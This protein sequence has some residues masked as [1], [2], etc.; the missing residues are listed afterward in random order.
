MRRTIL[1]AGV[2]PFVSAFLGGVLAFGLVA[3][4]MATAQSTAQQEVRANSFVLVND[5][6]AVVARLGINP[7]GTGTLWFLR[8]NGTVSSTFGQLGL[9][10]WDAGGETVVMRAGRCLGAGGA[11]CPGGLPPFEGLEL[12]PG[13]SVGMLPS[14]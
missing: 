11:P 12:G 8:T 1:L 13:G 5:S 6:G 9:A 2:L 7:V 3:P 4:S 14:Q 10:L